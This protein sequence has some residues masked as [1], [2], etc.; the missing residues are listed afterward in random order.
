M[1]WS[2]EGSLSASSSKEA[3]VTDV[4]ALEAGI[5]FTDWDDDTTTWDIVVNIPT[6]VW[7]GM[8]SEW[9]KESAV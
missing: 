7:D 6:T 3:A 5:G 2:K 4:F 9:S 8:T 1:S